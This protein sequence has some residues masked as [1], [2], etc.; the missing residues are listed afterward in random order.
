MRLTKYTH[1]CVLLDDGDRRLLI[2]P[3]TWTE[4]EALNGVTDVLVTHEHADPV[5]VDKL[6][7]ALE[8]EPE[9]KVFTHADVAPQLGQLGAAVVTVA[10]GDEFEAGGFGVRAVGGEHA[11]IYDGLPGCANLGFV[12]N[13]SA[14]SVYHPGD[15]CFVPDSSQVTVDTLLVPIS[16]PWLKLAEA[17][18]FVG[19][20]VP[21]RAFAIHD[22]MLSVVGLNSVDRWLTM[23]GGADYTRLEPGAS[24]ELG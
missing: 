24:A 8:R 17:I 21:A 3:G 6:A 2:D 18:E 11:E 10:S 22:A 13:T 9:L 1:A 4:P 7:A 19:T 20:V 15:A 5:D 12:V 14:G 16:G 23:K